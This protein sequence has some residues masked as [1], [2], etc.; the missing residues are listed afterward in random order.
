MSAL[1]DEI[2]SDPLGYIFSSLDKP[3]RAV[4]GLL[5]GRPEEGLAAIPFSDAIGLTDPANKV[6]GQDLLRQIGVLAPSDDDDWLP[7]LAGAG[8]EMASNPIAVGLG[9]VGAAKL[10][11]L[12]SKFFKTKPLGAAEQ[13]RRDLQ[14]LRIT[15]GD[16]AALAG[17]AP[18]GEMAFD[19]AG[20]GPKTAVLP[21]GG[22]APLPSTPLP[23]KAVEATG[24]G[25]A[26][27]DVPLWRSE[28][29]S[30]A[31]NAAMSELMKRWQRVRAGE[32]PIDI[33]RSGLPGETVPWWL[34]QRAV[35][36][37]LGGTAAGAGGLAGY[38]S[39]RRD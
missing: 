38:L 36:G 18:A 4:R 29:Y 2:T 12:A 37:A 1:L 20:S 27:Y 23:N 32:S 31:D 5:G 14:A 24:I 28:A 21:K 13:A 15:G 11:K 7:W 25:D 34:D 16:T 33:I 26:M 35:L 3:G 6:S 39:A 17:K 9:S 22:T 19:L 30:A 10:G 8:V